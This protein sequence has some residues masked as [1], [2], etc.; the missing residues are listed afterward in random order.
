MSLRGLLGP[1]ETSDFEGANEIVAPSGFYAPLIAAL[2]R[3]DLTVILTPSGRGAETLARELRVFTD[4]VEVFPDW[5]TLPHERLS[6]RTDTMARRI[7][8]LHRLTNPESFVTVDTKNS[9][10][11]S[12]ASKSQPSTVSNE[13]TPGHL[14]NTFTI[15]PLEP[16]HYL[17]VPMRAALA[18]VNVKILDYPIFEAE[19]GKLYDRDT[20]AQDLSSLGYERAELVTA[21]GQ[22]ALRGGIVDVFPA[23]SPHP[24]RIE[25]F[26]DEIDSIRPFTVADQRTFNQSLQKIVAPAC[27][28]LLLDEVAKEKAATLASEMPQAAE[29]LNLASQ[30]IYAEGLESLAPLLGAELKPL[31]ELLPRGARLIATDRP[32]LE[33]RAAELGETTQEFLAASWSAAVE[34]GE[35]PLEVRSA[36]FLNLEELQVAAAKARMKTLFVSPFATTDDAIQSGAEIIEPA[37][38]GGD[39]GLIG[40]ISERFRDGWT[41]VIAVSAKGMAERLKALL[42]EHEVPARVV[43]EVATQSG[44]GSA[45]VQV[46]VAPLEEGF[47]LPAA[48]LLVISEAEALGKRKSRHSGQKQ[49]L[50]SRRRKTIDPLTLSKGDFVVHVQHGIGRFVKLEKRTIGRGDKATSREYVV[51]EYAPSKR[52]GPPDQLWIPTDSLDL[53]S[54]YVGGDQPTL[55]KMGGSDWAKTK[56]KARKAVKEIARELVRLYAVRQASKGFAFSPDTPWQRELEDSFEFVET[57]DQLTTIDEVKSD[58]EK[59]IPMDRLICGDVGYGKTEIAVRAAFKAV[60]DGKQ[61]AVLAPTTLLVSQHLETFQNR[62]AGFPVTVE[63]LSRFTTAKEAARIKE[64]LQA[65]KIE[66]VI[67]THSLLSGKVRFK[68]LGL[69]IIDEE[70]RFGV[71]HKEALKALRANVDV[72]AMSATP[73]PRTLEMA[74]TGIRGLSTLTTPPEDRHPVLTYVGAY[75]DKQVAAAIRREMLRDGQVFFVHNR[76]QDIGRVAKH[77]QELV[78]EARIRVGHGQMPEAQLEKVMV[79]FWNQ[80]FDVLVSTTIVEN[81]LDVTNANTIIVDRAE[82]MGLSQL[83]QLRGRVGRG[84]ER[85]YAYFLYPSDLSLSETAFERLKTIGTNTSLGSGMAIAQKDLEIRGAGNLLGGEQ[86]GHIAGVGF[87]LYVRMVGEAVAA[88]SGKEQPEDTSVS[89][90]LPIDAYIPE[91]YLDVQSLR[92][93]AYTRLSN[94]TRDEE[95][96][97]LQDELRD[98]YGELPEPVERLAQLAKLRNLARAQGVHEITARGKFIRFTPVELADSQL[99]RLKRLYPAAR[100]KLATREL[101]VPAPVKRDGLAEASV[102]DLELMEWIEKIIKTI[103][104]PF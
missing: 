14:R 62:F 41:V 71:E 72:L 6:P 85:G 61:V 83:H 23:V 17:V 24:V 92:L 28:E 60:Q 102:L 99:A 19:V 88:Y 68:D 76:V 77:L 101:F 86:S 46:T 25:L 84:R 96:D 22:F 13:V 11:S 33:A 57:P 75:S 32:R 2:P 65:G 9:L 8:A 29:I 81:G 47:A 66:V 63:A 4:G 58:M 42:E 54:K 44:Y 31:F 51:L 12:K 91:D 7:W 49:N 55:S 64:D 26:G 21:R 27:R 56:Q 38:A 48:K 45:V 40:Q 52:N 90:E 18:P 78:P 80:E 79:D 1:I 82:R 30:G 97:Q 39:T 59:P 100:I 34:G 87:D 15:T 50:P 89:I 35:I 95:I 98:R 5:E 69:V 67:G 94:A 10:P 3:Q 74:I 103:I 53:L 104:K 70:Q 37:T 36:S 20:M 16:V 73:I 43:A 93:D